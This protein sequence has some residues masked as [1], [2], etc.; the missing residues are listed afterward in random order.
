M[1]VFAAA[2]IAISRAEPS[3]RAAVIDTLSTKFKSKVELDT[4]HVS[5]VKGLQVSGTGLR[6]FGDTDPNNREPGFQPIINVVEFKFRLG[7]LSFLRAPIHI[8]TVYVKGLQLNLPPREH[9]S[10]MQRME[11]KGGKI[12]IVVDRLVCDKAQLI[13]NTLKPGKLPLEFDI[14][15]LKMTT[16]A[17]GS[18]M[19]FDA[20]L[21]NPKPVGHILS[22]GL[23]GPWQPESPRDTP[24]SGTY[25]FDHADLSH[26]GNRRNAFLHR[27]IRRRSR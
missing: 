4:F 17:P 25:S 14:E 1:V 24:V 7:I 20:N 11:P 6:I 21:T 23:F 9:R 12:R 19:H 22:S 5:L 26:Q 27:Q 18:P 10:E 2:G 16:I 13:I 15:S 3:L 8:D